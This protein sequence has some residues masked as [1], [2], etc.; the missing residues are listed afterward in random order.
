M[1]TR[2]MSG[3]SRQTYLLNEISKSLAGTCLCQLKP[4]FS[5]MVRMIAN[6]AK[7]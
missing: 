3:F 7:V 5:N 2:Y 6:D 1:E 4:L